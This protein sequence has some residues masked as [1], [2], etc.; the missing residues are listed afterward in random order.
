MEFDHYKYRVEVYN[1]DKTCTDI[2][3][4]DYIEAANDYID[5]A[6][7]DTD[8]YFL[9]REAYYVKEEQIRMRMHLK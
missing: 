7:L 3:R 8:N 6:L 9:I 1:Q 5:K 4:F 2:Q